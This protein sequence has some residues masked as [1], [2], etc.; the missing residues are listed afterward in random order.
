MFP[1]TNADKHDTYS[2]YPMNI[3]HHF[4]V[5]LISFSLF[6]HILFYFIN[7]LYIFKKVYMLHSPSILSLS[8]LC[9]QYSIFPF[10]A[11]T[12]TAKMNALALSCLYG[13]LKQGENQLKDFIKFKAEKFYNNVS[14]FQIL[15]KSNNIKRHLHHQMA[16]L[17]TLWRKNISTCVQKNKTQILWST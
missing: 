15:L 2:L 9:L 6:W 5:F 8:A 12:A 14:T 17:P 16:F 13:Y 10:T 3:Y 1:T 4:S 7:H 11:S